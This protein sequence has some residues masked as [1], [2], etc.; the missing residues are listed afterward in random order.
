[1]HTYPWGLLAPFQRP[2][3]KDIWKSFDEKNNGQK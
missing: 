1:M 3:Y 2:F